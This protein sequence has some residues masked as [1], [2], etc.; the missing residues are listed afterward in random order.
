MYERYQ[1]NERQKTCDISSNK[2]DK[3]ILIKIVNYFLSIFK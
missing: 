1:D 3:R 2:K